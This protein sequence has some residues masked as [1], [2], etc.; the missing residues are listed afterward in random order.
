[1]LS[2]SCNFPCTQRNSILFSFDWFTLSLLWNFL[3][4]FFPLNFAFRIFHARNCVTVRTTRQL[5]MCV[6][7]SFFHAFYQQQREAVATA[8]ALNK[9]PTLRFNACTSVQCFGR[10]T[11]PQNTLKQKLHSRLGKKELREENDDGGGSLWPTN[12]QN[13]FRRFFAFSRWK[14]FDFPFNFSSYF[15][16]TK[17]KPRNMLNSAGFFFHWFRSL[18]LLIFVCCTLVYRHFHDVVASECGRFVT[19]LVS[20]KLN[21]STQA[22]Q[23]VQ[24]RLSHHNVFID[25]KLHD[26]IDSQFSLFHLVLLIRPCEYLY[27]GILCWNWNVHCPSLSLSRFWGWCKWFCENMNTHKIPFGKTFLIKPNGIRAI[28]KLMFVATLLQPNVVVVVI[29]Q[30]CMKSSGQRLLNVHHNSSNSLCHSLG[31]LN[32]ELYWMSALF[33]KF[34]SID[35]QIDRNQ[36][37]FAIL[38]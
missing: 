26:R 37:Q 29:V 11:F 2:L 27:A 28:S 13:C 32:T 16:Q 34:L 3:V 6:F 18:G 20:I 24:I 19:A 36:S 8:T 25:R 35:A 10:L 12:T 31:I 17:S 4:F 14:N 1:M 5:C 15:G 33:R 7:F 21:W 38:V 23:L 9:L 22:I 30:C